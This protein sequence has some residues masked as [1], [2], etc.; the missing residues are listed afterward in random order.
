MQE[1]QSELLIVL[2]SASERYDDTRVLST[3]S[4]RRRLLYFT[5]F[6]P[7]HSRESCENG[8]T[9]RD[10][11]WDVHSDGSNKACIR[12]GPGLPMRMGNL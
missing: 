3:R 6:T 2:T 12:W 11:V 7:M 4:T 9:D 10:A 5:L 8:W 1:M